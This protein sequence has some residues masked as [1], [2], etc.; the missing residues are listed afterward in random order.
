MRILW[1]STKEKNSVGHTEHFGL[2][3]SLMKMGHEVTVILASEQKEGTQG[4]IQF[5]RRRFKRLVLLK[6]QLAFQLLWWNISKKPD[7]IIIEWQSAFVAGILVILAKLNLCRNNLIHDIRT[8][9]IPP[10]NPHAEKI[11]TLC[12]NI[13]KK[14]FLGITTITQALKDKICSQNNIPPAKVGVWSSGVDLCL[15]YPRS[16]ATKKKALGLEGK[17]I[18]FYHGSVGHR[19]GVV[20]VVEAFRKLK[21]KNDKI[22]FFILGSGTEISTIC[23][24]KE[25]EKLD[26]VYIHPPVDYREVPDF[27]AMGDVCVVPLPDEECWRVSSPLKVMEYLAMGKPMI[28][29]DIKA[30]REIVKSS[31][32]AYFIPNIKPETLVTA[33]ETAYRSPTDL[34]R[35]GLVGLRNARDNCSWDIQAE[36]LIDYLD[37][38]RSRD[39]QRNMLNEVAHR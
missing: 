33:I 37:R 29:T 7:A 15:F 36:K 5:V 12:L 27:I 35:M 34:S 26:N 23:E 9:P 3:E 2:S 39:M 21:D 13:S 20:E 18:V 10:K 32:D 6:L 8:I 19:R 11:F 22:L 16:G 1:V 14:Y 38:I 4:Y 28:L 17:F 31:D 24:L 30:H 25:S